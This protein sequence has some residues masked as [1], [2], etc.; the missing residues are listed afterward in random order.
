MRRHCE[1]IGRPFEEIVLTAGVE[2]SL[3]ADPAAFVPT[4]VH[5]FYPDATFHLLGPAPTDVMAG[6]ERLVDVGVSH[7]QVSF[8]DMATY[9]RFL[10]EVV[11]SVRLE[12]RH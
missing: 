7:F 1:T 12:P 6:I 3:P 11:P 8:D 2:V 4:Y 9:R 5:A 10:D